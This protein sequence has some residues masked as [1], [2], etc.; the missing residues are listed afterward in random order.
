M[1][2]Y[3]KMDGFTGSV[4]TKGFENWIKLDNVEF[5]GVTTPVTILVGKTDD[6]IKGAPTF[7]NIALIVSE[8]TWHKHSDADL[9]FILFWARITLQPS[10][11]KQPKTAALA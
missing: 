7:S 5:G 1:A 2:I 4:S 8:Q 9:I 3:M 10:S 6:R 11:I